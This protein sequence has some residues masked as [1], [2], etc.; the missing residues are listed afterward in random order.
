MN[1]ILKLISRHLTILVLLLLAQQ[2]SAFYDP[3]VQRWVNRDPINEL[4]LQA[5]IRRNNHVFIT[6]E[7]HL[8][9]FVHNKPINGVDP[10]G[11]DIKIPSTVTTWFK[12]SIGIG[13]AVG[14]ADLMIVANLC[15]DLKAGESAFVETPLSRVLTAANAAIIVFQCPTGGRAY[16]KVTKSENG[17]DCTVD[18]YIIC[19]YAPNQA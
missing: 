6:E 3:S 17:V 16:R 14:F 8:Y 15:D 18:T 1:S 11:L 2:T 4:G 9:K 19:D 12:C 10:H 7:L 5:L 13:M